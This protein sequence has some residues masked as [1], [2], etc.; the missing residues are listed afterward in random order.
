MIRAWLRRWLGVP[1]LL[2]LDDYYTA[3]DVE[4][5]HKGAERS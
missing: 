3:I 2:D 4:A 5:F 1:S